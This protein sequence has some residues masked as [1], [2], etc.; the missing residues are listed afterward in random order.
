MRAP[1]LL[2][3]LGSRAN[4]AAT[5]IFR[6][7]VVRMA[8]ARPIVS[9]TF[10]DFPKSALHG[11]EILASYNAAG[12]FYLCSCFC[13]AAVEGIRYYDA[14]DVRFLIENNHEVG[15]HT[16]SHAH[17]S[18]M[19]RDELTAD[20]ERNAEFARRNFNLE[21]A[22]FS[23]PFGDVSLSSKRL[24]E[25]RFA[26]CR[27]SLP[28]V[29][30]S[31]ADLG[32]LRA[33]RLY[34]KLFDAESLKSLAERAAEP[35]SWLIFYTHDLGESPTEFGCTPAL[36]EAAVRAVIAAGFQVLT[37]KDAVA[38]LSGPPAPPA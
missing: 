38:A 3:K 12:T 25:R 33:V 26:A 7:R 32:A 36:F 24:V 8:N 29:N 22:T 9:F 10:D 2:A 28:G 6:T 20:L 11:A 35:G 34:A 13:G 4:R 18:R 15:C 17:V 5:A 14:G 23:F 30:R 16:A 21:L 19:R 27:S 37:V 1:K 31:L